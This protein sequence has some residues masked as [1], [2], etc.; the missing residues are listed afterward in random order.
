MSVMKIQVERGGKKER[1]TFLIFCGFF[2]M[3]ICKKGEVTTPVTTWV[4]FKSIPGQF[5]QVK[6]HGRNNQS[7]SKTEEGKPGRF[8]AD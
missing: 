8:L 1:N 2:I 6:R 7:G 3:L 4:L 5:Q